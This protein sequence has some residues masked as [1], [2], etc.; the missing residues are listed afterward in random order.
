[1]GWTDG[2]DPS[3]SEVLA[4]DSAQVTVGSLPVT[5]AV[6]AGLALVA[7]LL[8]GLGALVLVHRRRTA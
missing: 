3:S 2:G 7:A 8:L 1:M 4:S 5:G 6:A